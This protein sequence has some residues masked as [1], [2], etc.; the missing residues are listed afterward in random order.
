MQISNNVYLA[1][2]QTT[3]LSTETEQDMEALCIC[4]VLDCHAYE[5]LLI[6]KTFT[7]CYLSMYCILLSL[8]E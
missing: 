7:L 3:T 5:K 8:A 2:S 4:V 1:S 6:N